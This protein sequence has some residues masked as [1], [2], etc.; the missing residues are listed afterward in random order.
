MRVLNVQGHS[1]TV[2]GPRPHLSCP[3][4]RVA[5]I[6]AAPWRRRLGSC[7]RGRQHGATAAASVSGGSDPGAHASIRTTRTP[8]AAES[9]PG[10]DLQ[11]SCRRPRETGSGGDPRRVNRTD[12][13]LRPGLAAGQWGGVMNLSVNSHCPVANLPWRG[14]CTAHAQSV[15][16][17]AHYT[18]LSCRH[19]IPTSSLRALPQSTR[20]CLAQLELNASK[21]LVPIFGCIKP[22]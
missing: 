6:R 7:G 15:V 22:I 3:G 4:A 2:T 20:L 5:P 18:R 13:P 11:Q 12:R 21:H 8:N 14:G 16:V 1:L 19:D 17:S 10:C 9:T